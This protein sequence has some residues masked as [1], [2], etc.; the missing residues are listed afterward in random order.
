MSMPPSASGLASAPDHKSV[1]VE[2]ADAI[3]VEFLNIETRINDLKIEIEQLQRDR[4]S[5]ESNYKEVRVAFTGNASCVAGVAS[6][7]AQTLLLK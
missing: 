1:V 3:Q 6:L 5:L 2:S 7:C 4:A